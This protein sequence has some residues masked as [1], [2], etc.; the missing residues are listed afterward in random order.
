MQLARWSGHLSVHDTDGIGSPWAGKADHPAVMLLLMMTMTTSM[1]LLM[2]MMMMMM[3]MTLL[4]LLMMMMNSSRHCRSNEC[5]WLLLA[6]STT[7]RISNT[8]EM[9]SWPLRRS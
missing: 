8:G 9:T 1:M 5:I 7:L 6:G 4:L 3:M 2:M